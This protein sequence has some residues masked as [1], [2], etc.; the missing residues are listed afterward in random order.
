MILWAESIQDNKLHHIEEY[1]SQRY[2]KPSFTKNGKLTKTFKE[3][4]IQTNHDEMVK[5]IR[6]KFNILR[7]WDGTYF[8]QRK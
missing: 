5:S 2:K 1:F 3:W 8:I 4:F 7:D 6:D